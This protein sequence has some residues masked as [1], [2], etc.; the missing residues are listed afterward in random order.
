MNEL[1]LGPDVIEKLLPHR[2]PFLMVDRVVG[3]ARTPRPTLRACRNISANEPVFDG[4]FPGLHLW[5]GVHTIEGFGQ[6]CNLLYCVMAV[7]DG[8]RAHGRSEADGLA[9]LRNLE[10]GYRLEPGFDEASARELL[11][12]MRLQSAARAGMSAAVDVKLLRP[13]FAGDRLDYEVTLVR[14]MDDVAR[15]DVH[16]EVRNALVAKG[17]MTSTTHIPIAWSR[18]DA[19]QREK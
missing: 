9:A 7:E 11:D 3:Y 19:S 15:F 13:V 6:T 8:Y 1:A 14:I 16:A 4:H 10:L 2:R 12:N 17:T 18:G 5:P